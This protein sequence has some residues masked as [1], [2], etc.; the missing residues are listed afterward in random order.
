MGSG[1]EGRGNQARRKRMPRL[2]ADLR[3]RS[4]TQKQKT[5]KDLALTRVESFRNE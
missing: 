3:G 2:E 4:K 1:S 5:R